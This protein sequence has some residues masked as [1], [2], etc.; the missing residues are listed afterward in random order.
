MNQKKRHLNSYLKKI[1]DLFYTSWGELCISIYCGMG[2]F[3][4]FILH[5]FASIYLRI[6]DVVYYNYSLN[7][8]LSASVKWGSIIL[9]ISYVLLLYFRKFAIR[10]PVL[11]S[12]I[13]I[14]VISLIFIDGFLI[15]E[16]FNAWNFIYVFILD[17]IVGFT[18][19]IRYSGLSELA[20]V[21]HISDENK[22][23]FLKLWHNEVL[24][25][26]SIL[27][28]TIIIII[29][30]GLITALAPQMPYF[31]RD[32][33]DAYGVFLLIFNH[34]VLLIYYL[35]GVW[36]GILGQFIGRLPKIRWQ[37]SQLN[38]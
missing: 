13:I 5:S 20:R 37:I 18:I 21:Q 14:I 4:F 22:V 17:I 19:Y 31:Q 32:P 23:E 34:A 8:A 28:H 27:S 36:F 38:K 6:L 25:H 29:T 9:F 10:M 11:V 7:K 30:G 3:T 15:E 35:V 2:I 24:Q 1:S 16:A 12:L 33:E 26:I